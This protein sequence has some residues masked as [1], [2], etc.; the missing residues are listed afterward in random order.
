M[1]CKNDAVVY[2]FFTH[3]EE[4]QVIQVHKQKSRWLLLVFYDK[5]S[6]SGSVEGNRVLPPKC[7]RFLFLKRK[8]YCQ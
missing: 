5:C 3:Q 8:L 7:F 2:C 1:A 4:H 6:G